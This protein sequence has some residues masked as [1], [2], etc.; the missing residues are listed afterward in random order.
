MRAVPDSVAS[1]RSD[2]IYAHQPHHAVL[3]AGLAGLSKV[4]EYPWR[5]VDTVARRVRGADQPQEPNVFEGPL[6]DRLL[7][8][9]VVTARS[10][11]KHPAH[12]SNIEAI[13]VGFYK[14]VGLTDLPGTGFR[15]H[16][17]SSTPVTP[18]D[19]RVH[20]KLGSPVR[21]GT[22]GLNGTTSF[23][24]ILGCRASS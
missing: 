24:A 6:T 14:F 10:H 9:G 1:S 13:A 3:A 18:L 12:R 23:L 15:T 2:F 22:N 4:E 20:K 7:E 11:L 16:R 17:H 21:L 5:S 19:S 8:P